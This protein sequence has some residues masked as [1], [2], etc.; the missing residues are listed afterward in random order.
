[1]GESFESMELVRKWWTNVALP[2]GAPRTVIPW[3]WSM[4]RTAVGRDGSGGRGV[5]DQMVHLV[6]LTSRPMAPNSLV[7]VMRASLKNVGSPAR[8]VSSA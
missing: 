2:M 5:G 3:E 1:M 6:R 4:I 8:V 7:R